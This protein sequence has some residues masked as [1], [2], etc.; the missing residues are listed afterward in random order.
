MGWTGTKTEAEDIKEKTGMFLLEKL[1]LEMSDEKTVI[2]HAREGKATFLNYEIR[3]SWDNTTPTKAKGG[4]RRSVNGH[5]RFEVPNDVVRNW[6]RKIQTGKTTKHRAELM[7]NSDYDIVMTYEQQIRG[8]INDYTFAHDVVKKMKKIRYAYGQS[9]VKTLAAKYKTSVF[10]IYRKYRGYTAEGKKIIMVKEVRK[11]K[12]P[13]VASYGKTTIRQHRKATIKDKN[14]TRTS[15]R[16]ELIQ[17]LLNNQCELCGKYGEVAGHHIRKLKDLKKRGRELLW[18]QKRMIALRR[19]TLFVC[20][21]CHNKIHSG[22]YDG[23]KL[24]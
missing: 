22:T 19:K 24:T 16:T 21:E 13:L 2:P 14:P 7:N 5:L 9:L 11:D 20:K 3:V 23:R 12:P 8:L 17:R 1:I 10:K 18:W 4:K 15:N 6:N